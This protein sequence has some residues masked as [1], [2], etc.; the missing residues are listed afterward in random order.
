M[1]KPS[2]S[3]PGQV[4]ATLTR[5]KS[6]YP[7]A[8]YH[9]VEFLVGHLCDCSRAFSGDL[10]ELLILA[11]IGQMHLRACTNPEQDGAIWRSAMDVDTSISASRLSDV[12]GIPRQTVRRKLLALK[13]RG[14]IAQNAAG[15]WHIVLDEQGVAI[16]RRDLAELDDRSLERFA[17]LHAALG[18]LA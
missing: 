5:F 14:W 9:C 15:R 2:D 13:S 7:R 4:D 12:T 8:Q 16:S 11:L 6:Q 3:L 1:K 18:R 10:Q 17:R